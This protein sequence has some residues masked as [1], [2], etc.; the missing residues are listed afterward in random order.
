VVYLQTALDR[1]IYKPRGFISVIT[2]IPSNG[3]L[4]KSIMRRF[5]DK[6]RILG[7]TSQTRLLLGDIA[8]MLD[9]LKNV[10]MIEI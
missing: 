6:T 9:I 3:I 1:F 8:R 10:S 2:A 7:G 4:L 5:N